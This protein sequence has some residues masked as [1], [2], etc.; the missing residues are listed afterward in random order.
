[1]KK[2]VGGLVLSGLLAAC[3]GGGGVQYS[4]S[5]QL[6]NIDFI[7]QY[8]TPQDYTYKGSLIPAGTDILC[9]N[10]TNDIA[11]DIQWSGDLAEYAFNLKGYTTGSETEV[12]T[13]ELSGIDTSGRR[14]D[15]VTLASGAAPL[16]INKISK[17]AII[18][19]PITPTEVNVLG[20]SYIQSFGVDSAGRPT[21]IYQSSFITLVVNCN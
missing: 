13:I 18:P 12:A 3:G 8:Y 21:P 6:K 20:A 14:S 15:T 1:M 19:T 5:L 16:R 4:T 17:Q 7:S 11:T 2:I 10:R 9:K